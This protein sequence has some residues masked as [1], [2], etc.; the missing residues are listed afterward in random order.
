MTVMVAFLYSMI[1]SGMLAPNQ[2]L[3][4]QN[5]LPMIYRC[6]Q[7][8]R[9]DLNPQSLELVESVGYR[10]CVAVREMTIP[11]Y[12]DWRDG[13]RGAAPATPNQGQ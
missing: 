1:Q 12:M 7:Y 6:E 13:K 2:P 9:A 5:G 11:E 4:N 3:P 8:R 10:N